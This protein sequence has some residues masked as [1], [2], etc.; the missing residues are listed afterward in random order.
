VT[1]APEHNRSL[2]GLP[3]GWPNEIAGVDRRVPVLDGTTRR[4]VNLDNAASTPPLIVVRDAVHRFADWYSSVHRGSGFKSQL[5]THV[6]ESARALVADFVGIDPD[7]HVVVFTRHTTEA[8]NKMARD[9]ARTKPIVFTTIM[10]HHANM[11]PWRV[12]AG[13]LRF[14]AVD[15]DG[16]LD[17]EDL[18]RQLRDAPTDRPRLVAIAGAYNVSGHTPPIH[19]IARLAHR[20]GA[21]IFVDGAQLVPHRRVH[22]RGTGADDAIDFL[23]FSSH[24]LYAPYGVGVLVAPREAFSDT[25]D[26]LGG[27]IVDLVTLDRVVW[28]GIP[29]REEAGSPNVIGVVALAAAIRRLCELGM[30][31]LAEHEEALTRY[32]LRRFADLPDVRV[33]GPQDASRRVGVVAFTIDGVPDT[34]AAAVL[35]YEWAIGVRAGCFCAHPGTSH[36]LC[37]PPERA[38]E[39]QAQIIA[40]VRTNVPGA[41]RASIGLH[42]TPNDVQYFFEA[43]D[44]IVERRFSQTYEPD[45]TSGEYT[46]AGWNPD[47]DS[48]FRV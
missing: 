21:R 25:P 37:I 2:A 19:D 32:A 26:Q 47:Y 23:A 6:L 33:L 42:N 38:S 35:A 11:L 12:Y 45:A 44:S 34:L 30:D 41:V 40:H 22:M 24:K 16:C 3:S 27:G 36:L 20:Y 7:Q 1:L 46:P 15:Q 29:E 43:L 28:A 8:I 17:Q 31:N 10:E 18:E 14:I 13:G 48:F 4:Y 39:I 5:S 9:L